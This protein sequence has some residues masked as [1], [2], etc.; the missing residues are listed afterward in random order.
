MGSLTNTR[1]EQGDYVFAHAVLNMD[2]AAESNSGPLC[3]WFSDCVS[4]MYS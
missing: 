3:T 2:M 1:T 4:L